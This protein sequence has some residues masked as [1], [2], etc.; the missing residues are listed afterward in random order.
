[1]GS[2]FKV[3]GFGA[4]GPPS[5]STCILSNSAPRT[6]I[7][8]FSLV[9]AGDGCGGGGLLWFGP[10]LVV[11]VHCCDS[12]NGEATTADAAAATTADAAAATTADAAAANI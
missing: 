12:V 5:P 9:L 4:C 11:L 3:L 1:M 6:A 7:A 2:R 8:A 10:P